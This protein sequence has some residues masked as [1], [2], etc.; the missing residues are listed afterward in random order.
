M[1]KTLMVVGLAM[2]VICACFED[3][4]GQPS[5]PKIGYGAV[6]S[7]GSPGCS[8][9]NPQECNKVPANPYQRGCEKENHCREGG[10][11]LLEEGN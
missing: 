1:S 8:A 9:K 10:R 6:G 2:M 5:S 4:A 7:G 3:A 11:K